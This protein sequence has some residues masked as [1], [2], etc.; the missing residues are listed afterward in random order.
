MRKHAGR[1]P[2]KRIVMRFVKEPWK[3]RVLGEWSHNPYKRAAGE[4]RDPDVVATEIADKYIRLITEKFDQTGFIPMTGVEVNFVAHGVADK[5]IID[6]IN[7]ENERARSRLF[8]PAASESLAAQKALLEVPVAA[9]DDWKRI[10]ENCEKTHAFYELALQASMSGKPDLALIR[11]IR[12]FTDQE[13][14]DEIREESGVIINPEFLKRLL[15]Y[16]QALENEYVVAP[17]VGA[18]SRA[19][20]DDFTIPDHVDAPEITT[21]PRSPE[22]TIRQVNSIKRLLMESTYRFHGSDA[23]SPVAKRMHEA[24]GDYDISFI[25]PVKYYNLAEQVSFSL[26]IKRDN[27]NYQTIRRTDDFGKTN[28]LDS[29]AMCTLYAEAF[30]RYLPA[31][32]LLTVGNRF[33]FDEVKQ[34]GVEN[35]HV[36]SNR[37]NRLG[38]RAEICDYHDA[39]SNLSLSMLGILS[40]AYITTVG[41][42]SYYEKRARSGESGPVCVQDMLDE[43]EA[44]LPFTTLPKTPQGALDQFVDNGL[45]KDMMYL[46]G[47]DD[48]MSRGLSKEDAH[49]QVLA[50]IQTFYGA[51]VKRQRLLVDK[52]W[53]GKVRAAKERA[54]GWKI[55]NPKPDMREYLPAEAKAIISHVERELAKGEEPAQSKSL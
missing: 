54:N 29:P 43:I 33:P 9:S 51:L 52:P 6:Y 28:L 2:T 7:Q 12:D 42:L 8:G 55:G 45:T 47:Y 15:R 3:N 19:Y 27:T 20:I 17:N 48:A 53:G 44:R 46:A 35:I 24:L 21:P 4:T 1:F 49:K 13:C 18:I 37:P 36:R 25:D 34:R 30:A 26:Q 14:I 50:E 32:R 5:A 38:G 40:V 39:C 31:D 22:L 11:Y 41:V 16:A 10:P 23:I